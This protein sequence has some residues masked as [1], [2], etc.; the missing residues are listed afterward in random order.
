MTELSEFEDAM[1]G[2]HVEARTMYFDTLHELEWLTLAMVGEAGEIANE[3][4][5]M[6]R[7]DGGLGET[8]RQLVL[9]E[10][11]NVMV[12]LTLMAAMLGVPMEDVLE[13]GAVLAQEWAAKRSASS[14]PAD[15][16]VDD[17]LDVVATRRPTS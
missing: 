16:P 3:V 13:R 10:M 7:D 15:H 8:R 1:V 14:P 9:N 4:K 12:Y 11:G 6:R 2:I 17:W 5:K